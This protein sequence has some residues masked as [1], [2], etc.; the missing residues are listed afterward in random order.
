[1]RHFPLF[2]DLQG[3]DVAV[4][5]GGEVAL[6]KVQALLS[7]GAVVTVVAP[8]LHEALAAQLAQRTPQSVIADI[9]SSTSAGAGTLH[10]VP[11]ALPADPATILAAHWFAQAWLVVAATDNEA[12]NAAVA[13][14]GA[15]AR[16]FVNVVDDSAKCSA[17]VPAVIDRSPLLV[18][19]STSGTAPMLARRVRRDIELLLDGGL[20]RLAQFFARWR[21]R[22]TAAVRTPA[23][24]RELY[25]RW[26]DGEVARL[27]RAGREDAAGEALLASL[28]AP[29]SGPAVATA[30]AALAAAAP[31]TEQL[32]QGH[33]TLVGA[34]PGDAGLL[35]LAGLQALQRADVIL[36]DRLVSAEVRALARRDALQIEVGKEGGGHSV[37][38]EEIHRLLVH[39]AR[40][41]LNVVRLKGGDPFVFGRGGEELLC[42]RA[43]GIPYAVV[44][45]VTA[46]LACA[47]QAGLPLTHRDVARSVRFATAH[48]RGSSDETDWT[49]LAAEAG[50]LVLYMGLSQSPRVQREL[51]TRGRSAALPAAIIENG[52][53][54]E[55]RVVLTTLGHLAAA[56]R[57]LQVGSPALLILGPAVELAAQLHWQ[58]A[59]PVVYPAPAAATTLGGA[60]A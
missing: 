37:T 6:R 52:G 47:A 24:R 23:R 43:A 51:L 2:L 13:A 9:A 17:I 36:V 18:A 25:D 40:E 44:P 57:E 5:G 33:V 30:D 31:I 4:V 27:V 10:H 8:E 49:G 22:V 38:Q 28:E 54:P 55:Q 15:A 56:V 34:G 42:L 59:A 45:G 19:V 20:G 14:A 21:E 12:V 41:G 48:C 26:M 53:R 1:M 3:R 39:Y 58:G 11:A 60:A 32:G 46:A 50:T 29:P 35:T 16:K 7:A